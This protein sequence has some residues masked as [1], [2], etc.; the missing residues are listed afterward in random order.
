MLVLLAWSISMPTPH[1][2][3][4]T[5]NNGTIAP[6]ATS[7]VTALA[8]GDVSTLPNFTVAFIGDSGDGSNGDQR[9]DE[10]LH[11][12]QT[13]GAE[14]VVHLGDFV[15]TPLVAS[16]ITEL[17]QSN[18]DTILGPNFLYLGVEGNHD[19]WSSFEPFF[20]ERLAR[21][22]YDPNTINGTDYALAHNGLKLVFVGQNVENN[23]TF[24]SQNLAEDRHIWKICGWHQNMNDF[25]AGGKAD[26]RLWTEYQI[27]Q[28]AGAII[29]TGHEHSYART[30]TLN[31]P[32]H[33]AGVHRTTGD[34][35]QMWVERGKPGKSFVFVNGLGGYTKRAYRADLHDDDGWWATIYT[36]TRYCRDDC[37]DPVTQAQQRSADIA[38]YRYN[39]G[40]LFITFHVDD[41]PY[42]ARGYFKTIDGDVIDTFEIHAVASTPTP[43]ATPTPT[44]TATTMMPTSTPSPT[45]TETPI[46]PTATSTHTP[47]ATPPAQDAPA[48]FMPMLLGSP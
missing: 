29:A 16:T 7:A 31:E 27:C 43:S 28:D 19:V 11:L 34:S 32:A 2:A 8:N 17:W 10:V 20:R 39:H 1:P 24:L 42:K 23:A 36:S 26:E 47:T 12:I 44:S 18:I 14:M 38:A 4:A 45:P 9:F 5:A 35:G 22:H 25:Q 3:E 40:A 46:D 15:Y 13:E 6:T 48:I 37:T 30:L 33:T 41:D 21:N